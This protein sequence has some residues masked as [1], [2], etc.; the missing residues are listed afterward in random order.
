MRAWVTGIVVMAMLAGCATTTS[1]PVAPPTLAPRAELIDTPFFPQEPEQCG[2]AALATVLNFYGHA[3]TPDILRTWVYVPE[4]G[5][6]LQLEIAATAR[7]HDMLAYPLDG[8]LETL[9]R[10]L[11]GGHPVLVLQNLG[12]SWLPRWH[13]VVAIGYD[14]ERRVLLLRSGTEPRRE[15]DFDVFMN[16]WRRG[17]A[18]ALVIIPSDQAPATAE[19]ETWL[20]AA[21]DLEATQR[22]AAAHRA[23]TTIATHAPDDARA[24]LGLAN[25]ALHVSRAD[26]AA[27][28]YQHALNIQ[29]GQAITWNNFAY[30]LRDMF[31]SDEARRAVACA[32]ALAP[33]DARV[34]ESSREI[35]AAVSSQRG[36]TCPMLLACPAAIGPLL[37]AQP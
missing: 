24:W 29:P 34:V 35:N 10:E 26:A 31:C 32:V 8:E 18:W 11:A 12:L 37:P 5:G 13:Y 7:R 30:A 9:L 14:L 33:S 20:H 36:A 27:H 19:L 15:T 25:N 16:T 1:L 17:G 6:S 22:Y 21:A 28:A 2:P 3:T 23:F 4:R